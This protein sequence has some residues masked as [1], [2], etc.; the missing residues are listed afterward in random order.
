MSVAY[1]YQVRSNEDKFVEILE[2][3]LRLAGKINI[4]GKFW[5]EFLPICKS[6]WE[7]IQNEGPYL[8]A[9]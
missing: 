4:P 7:Y 5:V 6:S 9:S 8:I 2:G 3:S 1:G